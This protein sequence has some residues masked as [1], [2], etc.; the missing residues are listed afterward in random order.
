MEMMVTKIKTKH[1]RW[2]T[3]I[4]VSMGELVTMIRGT[5]Q[6]QT[7]ER[8]AAQARDARNAGSGS[9]SDGS[10]RRL[11]DV[12]DRLPYLI[13][14]GLFTRH[15]VHDFEQPTGLMLLSIPLDGDCQK[16][17]LLRRGAEQL[18][19]T[20]MAFT[21]T[22]RRT[23]KVIVRCL[24]ASGPL[25]ADETA[26]L[27]FMVMAQQQALRYYEAMLGCRIALEQ[28]SLQRG[29]RM[30]QDRRAYYNP[31]AVP[32][33]VLSTEPLFEGY[34]LARTDKQGFTTSDPEWSEIERQRTDFYAC[35]RQAK[36]SVAVSPED[37]SSIEK[38]V[39][40][41]ATL[42][43]KSGLPEEW[44]VKRTGFYP[45]WHLTEEGVRQIFRTVYHKQPE[46]KPWSQMS[47]KELVA[48]K[49]REFMERRYELRYNVMKRIE[50]YRP[51]GIDY[52]PWLTLTDRD[53]S[54]I[55]QE[56]MMEAGAA[57]PIGVE[58]Y[59]RSGLTPEYNPIHE[60]LAGCG[61]W[62]GKRDY[63]A[64]LARRVPC[65]YAEWP[66]LFRR[67]FLGMVAAW[68]GKS[69][70]HANGVV[71][72]LIGPQGCRK[73]TFCKQLLPHSL[74]EYYIDDIK[75]DNA[76]QV[77][78]MLGRMALV[79]IDEYNAKTDREQAKI[80]RI[81][82]ERDVQVRRPRSD[83][84]VMVQRMASFIATTNE[85]QPLTDN[86]GS[87]RYL[88]VEVT[89]T[90]DTV[91]PIDYRQLYAQ[92][93]ALLEQGEPCYMTKEEERLMQEHN[94][95]FQCASTADILLTSY[96]R[97]APRD[98]AYFVRA[99]DI[100]ACL[101]QHAIGSDRPNMS[102]LVKALKGARFEYGAQNGVRGWYAE[103]I[104]KR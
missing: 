20:V 51:K 64:E 83:Q 28:E 74:R 16:A 68:L 46:G 75:L 2:G 85:R 94:Q 55:A 104:E 81:L 44:A 1:G 97:P 60:F 96:Y 19:Q 70:D 8:I 86:T 4:K 24:P 62:D 69:R 9:G 30:S 14:S 34:P 67:W 77:E 52:H 89:G 22:S 84:Y 65:N 78:R 82:T 18:P 87:R 3:P 45:D 88:C 102:R 101:Q 99:V 91:T 54:R 12:R 47:P 80:K 63:I 31:A 71:P 6:E 66:Q 43:R 90:I 25:P 13:F 76:E 39:I 53:L 57:W 7:V 48:R 36:D 11:P 61:R 5:K 27:K 50:E 35:F 15:G 58:Q 103:K 23:L 92:A 38:F 40:A 41:L 93:L 98:K 33:T 37:P 100:L 72:M 32:L 79:N 95:S 21:G 26:Y 42:C 73:S 49:V 17:A 56:Q 10:G 59:C 29:C